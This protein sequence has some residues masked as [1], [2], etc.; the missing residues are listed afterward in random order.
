VAVLIALAAMSLFAA[1]AAAGILGVVSLAD[2]DTTRSPR[3]PS[4]LRDRKTPSG[5]SQTSHLAG[6]VPSH[7]RML[8][9]QSPK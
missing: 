2:S 6:P 9:V 7:K 5:S 8:C 1:G 3:Y 4:E